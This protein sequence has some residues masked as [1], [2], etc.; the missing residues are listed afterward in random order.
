VYNQHHRL[1]ALLLVFALA[2][3]FFPAP[4]LAVDGVTEEEPTISSVEPEVELEAEPEE[5]PGEEPEGSELSSEDSSGSATEP[6]EEDSVAEESVSQEPSSVQPEEVQESSVVQ[7]STPAKHKI[8]SSAT[9]ISSLIQRYWNSDYF[10][11]AAVDPKKNKVTMDGKT[12]SFSKLFGKG[13]DKNTVLSSSETVEDFF[14]D[15]P[16]ETELQKDG[17]VTVTAPYQTMRIVVTADSLSDDFGAV[18]V[19]EYHAY[20]QYVLQFSTE[21][22]TQEAYEQLLAEYGEENCY[23]DEV[24]SAEDVLCDVGNCTSWGVSYMGMDTLKVSYASG[25][26]V[27]VAV[28]DTGIDPDNSFFEGRIHSGSR[29]LADSDPSDYSDEDGHGTHVAGIVADSTPANVEIMALRVFNSIGKATLLSLNTALQYAIEQ[30]VDVINVSLG[31]TS[32][33]SGQ[34]HYLDTAISAAYNAG[35]PICTS[36]GNDSIDMSNTY[37]A[38]N[39]QTITVSSISSDGSFSESFSNYGK[40]VDFCA[41]GDQIVS[42]QNGGGLVAKSGTSMSSPHLAAACAWFKLVYPNVSVSRLYELLKD[43][44]EDLGDEGWDEYYGWGCPDLSEL[45]AQCAAQWE[46]TAVISPTCSQ[47]GYTLYTCP[48]CLSTYKDHFT[49]TIDHTLG[50]GTTQSDG[51]VVYPCLVCGAEVVYQPFDNGL[52]WNLDGHGTLTIS[53]KGTIQTAPWADSADQVK[54]ITLKAGVT[55]IG[56]GVFSNYSALQTIDLPEGLTTIGENA[57]YNCQYL[58]P[59]IL[60]ASVTSIGNG[61][62]GNCLSLSSFQLASGNRSFV[63]NDD[64][65]LLTADKK[66]LVAVAPGYSPDGGTYVHYLPS[67]VTTIAPRAFDGCYALQTLILS[68]SLTSIGSSAF[69]N[70]NGLKSIYFQGNK[71]TIGKNSFQS[72]NATVYVS[73]STS[74]WS[75]S[76]AKS[77]YG[78]ILTWTDYQGNA[79]K[80]KVT[81]RQQ[82]W[83]Y[84]GSA[85]RPSVVVKSDGKLLTSGTDYT[86]SYSSNTNAGTAKLTIKGRGL[87]F[88]SQTVK[89]TIS[90]QDISHMTPTLSYTKKAATGSALKPTVTLDDLVSG[91]DYSVSYK[92]NTAPGTATVTVTGKGNYTGQCKATFTITL[93]APTLS[94][95]S[96]ATSGITVKWKKVTYASGYYVYRKAGSA[97]KWTKVKT[98]TKGSTLSWTDTKATSNGTN[99]TYTVKAYRNSISG[100]YSTAGIS[101]YRL[102]RP[103]IS[104]LKNSSGK[105]MTVKW[106]K[107][108]KATGYQIQY[109]TSSSFSSYK[110]VTVSKNSTVSQTISSLTKGKKY[111]VRIRSYVTVDG[112]NRYSAWSS[113]KNVKISK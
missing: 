21:E 30:E 22:A 106:G 92:N 13:A 95:A 96:N 68:P 58:Q 105:E 103:T 34:N 64:V 107:N 45:F 66:T 81:F 82:Q 37:P 76:G 77:N 18:E 61:A 80:F 112:T 65:V 72:V 74:G 16:Y 67:T 69:R 2:L 24:I 28:I 26:P 98:I 51:S 49:E 55:G 53:G 14:Q 40:G 91:T 97:T 12:T 108:S 110:T 87:Y 10:Q 86:I 4:A 75:A 50:E 78:G 57:F 29:N 73:S 6:P 85:V 41:P 100:S 111:Y 59:F 79:A 3:T 109:S 46:K 31:V 56:T 83:T 9:E 27:V 113:T 47:Q 11:E 63:V 60:P 38:C 90:P 71:P 94:S 23:V 62:F 89:F 7:A 99:Y 42:A 5:E 39:L 84:T 48:S 32:K 20:D 1:T 35:I 88:G 54:T 70:C 104:S 33:T 15:T 101:C 8:V 44:S 25:S 102:T 36:A 52:L 17:T 19:L 93:A 43:C